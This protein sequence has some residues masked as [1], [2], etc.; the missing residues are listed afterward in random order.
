M[1]INNDSFSLSMT[2]SFI[3][4]FFII[5]IF[6]IRLINA[7]QHN[8]YWDLRA[9]IPKVALFYKENCK[10]VHGHCNYIIGFL[11]NFKIFASLFLLWLSTVQTKIFKLQFP[12]KFLNWNRWPL[13][14]FWNRPVNL[15]KF[16]FY[17]NFLY[18]LLQQ[19]E[20]KL[21]KYVDV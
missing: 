21:W 2:I 18:L 9:S 1:L 6:R 10:Q 12:S 14:R 3:F 17:A 13:F 19:C 11:Q 15:K 4:M 20:P 16:Y 8:T 5:L 7:L